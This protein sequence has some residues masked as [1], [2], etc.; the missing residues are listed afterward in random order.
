MVIIWVYAVSWEDGV[1][2]GNEVNAVTLGEL[3]E[4][5]WIACANFV[6]WMNK[7]IGVSRM[8]GVNWMHGSN[9]SNGMNW[10]NRVN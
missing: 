10:M 8:H 6:N 9:G 7:V 2:E 5:M 3:D 1:N 4:W